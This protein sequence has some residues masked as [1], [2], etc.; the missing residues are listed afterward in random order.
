M[1]SIDIN[2]ISVH[3]P[4]IRDV[5]RC[6]SSSSVVMAL[7][8]LTMTNNVRTTVLQ[9]SISGYRRYIN[10]PSRYLYHAGYTMM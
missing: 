1:I 8:R 4:V 9:G 6:Q 2:D 5:Y 7:S 3:S 10:R